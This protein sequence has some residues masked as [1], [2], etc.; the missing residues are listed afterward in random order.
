MLN[1]LFSFQG[2]MNRAPYWGYSLLLFA[3]IFLPLFAILF[4]AA[5]RLDGIPQAQ[6]EATL[7]RDFIWLILGF[8]ALSLWPT[9]AL[10]AK[11]LQDHG[12]PGKLAI[13]LANAAGIIATDNPML[14]VLGLLTVIVG[15]FNF[16]YLGCMRGTIGANA[17][18]EDPVEAKAE[19]LAGTAQGA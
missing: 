7:Q 3:L 2:R 8:T 18:G 14:A 11:R 5:L 16:V 9:L 4:A 6:I 19:M 1:A 13:L 10:M 17:Y 12:K 15:L